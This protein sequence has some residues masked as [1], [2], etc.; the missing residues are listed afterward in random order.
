M[1]RVT[2][3]YKNI[4]EIYLKLPTKL[5]TIPIQINITFYYYIQFLLKKIKKCNYF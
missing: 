5:M 1:G 2:T 3:E 4:W